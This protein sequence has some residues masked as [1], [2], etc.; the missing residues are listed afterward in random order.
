MA[1][2]SGVGARLRQIFKFYYLKVVRND[3]SPEYIARGVALGLA[4]GFIIPMFFQ[5]MV[6]IPLS[7]VLRAAKVPAI[8]GT[9]VSNHFTVLVLYPAQCWIGGSLLM[10]PISYDELTGLLKG[11]IAN[12][13]WATFRELGVD[14]GGAFFAGGAL[15]A[16]LVATPAYFITIALVKKYRKNRE[17]RRARR[18]AKRL[19]QL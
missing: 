4:V 3:G 6:A 5:L 13:C 1:R 12:P 15:F 9:F 14:V 10:K 19:K 8:V 17:I 11:V 18:V 16:L 7:F 2:V